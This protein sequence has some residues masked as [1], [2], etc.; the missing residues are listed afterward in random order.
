MAVVQTA[1]VG[2]LPHP[3]L[4]DAILRHRTM[5][6]GLSALSARFSRR[7]DHR[8]SRAHDIRSTSL[9]RRKGEPMEEPIDY[10]NPRLPAGLARLVMPIV[11]AT[12][13]ALEGYGRLIAEPDGCRIEIVRWPAL[14][15]RRVD[16]GTGDQGGTT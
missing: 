3:V 15:T 13:S 1:M 16:A 11:D 7:A 12:P 8:A 10:L 6:E 2:G 4:R 14:G 5:A 9:D